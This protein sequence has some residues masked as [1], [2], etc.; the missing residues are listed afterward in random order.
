[1]TY[2]NGIKELVLTLS[3]N[4]MNILEWFVGASYATHSDTNIHT[5]SVLE[6]GKVS[7]I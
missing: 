4:G 3:A 5:G 7:K 2:F 6:M 1:M